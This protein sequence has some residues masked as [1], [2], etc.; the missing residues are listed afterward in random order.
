MSERRN[1][2]D[3]EGNYVGYSDTESRGSIF[4]IPFWVL[5]LPGAVIS[6]LVG[7]FG[8]VGA[9]LKV[10]LVYGIIMGA[11][12]LLGV[13][14]GG[15]MVLIAK[16]HDHLNEKTNGHANVIWIILFIGLIV[17]GVSACHNLLFS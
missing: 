8:G 12:Y 17:G 7:I 6:V 5:L 13:L 15:V 11:F 1:Y 9:M 4:D 16:L 3:D 10:A 2:Y 14:L